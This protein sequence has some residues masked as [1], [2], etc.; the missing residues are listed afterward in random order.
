VGQLQWVLGRPATTGNKWLKG[1]LE[2]GNE[3]GAVPSGGGG[4]PG[5]ARPRLMAAAAAA[6]NA[7]RASA[8]FSSS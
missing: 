7:F 1:K 3:W 4:S 8:S 2:K 5:S 6:S